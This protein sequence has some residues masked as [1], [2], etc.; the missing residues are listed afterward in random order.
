M[1]GATADDGSSWSIES[2]V[3]YI[4]KMMHH[5]CSQMLQQLSKHKADSLQLW[6][7]NW[8]P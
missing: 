4:R 5:L 3:K 6:T 2:V 1:C 8:M 7:S